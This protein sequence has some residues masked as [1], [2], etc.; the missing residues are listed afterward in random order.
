[1][2]PS[3][4]NKLMPFLNIE[5]LTINFPQDQ[6]RQDVVSTLSL[7]INPGQTTALVGESGSG[8]SVTALSILNLLP[9]STRYTADSRILFHGQNLLTLSEPDLHKIRGHKIAMIFQEPMTSLNPLMT[10]AKQIG[11]VL[12]IHKN[13]T[14]KMAEERMRQLLEKVGFNPSNGYL[15]RYP[16]EL[17]GG[18]RQ[19]VM[20]AMALAGEP[21]LLIADEPTTALDVTTQAQILTLLKD[22][23]RDT[24]MALLLITHDLNIVRAVA[25]NIAVMRHG[26]IVEY[27]S[28][29]TIFAQPQHEYTRKLIDAEP[30]GRAVPLT[31]DSATVL[32]TPNLNVSFIKKHGLLQRRYKHET[33]HAVQN[34]DIE[35]KASETVGLVG[36]SGSGKTTLGLA[37]LRLQSST[38]PIIFM[39]QNIESLPLKQLQ[40]LRRHM[41]IV[42]QDP[43][44]S[45]SPRMTVAQIIAEGAHVHGIVS[46]KAEQDQLVIATMQQVGLD[47]QTRDRY[48]HEFSGGQRQR[49][50]IA[51]ALILRPQLII[52]DEPTSALDRPIQNEILQLLKKLQRDHGI[53]YLFI[54]HDLKVI[55]AISHRVM[56]MYQGQIIESGST[57][58]IFD[59]PEHNYTKKL[60]QAAFYNKTENM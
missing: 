39:E 54:S 7:T 44:G 47:P 31:K 9:A 42:F 50:A 55:R 37:L 48:P 14:G 51:R 28:V 35:I 18:Q 26:L 57:E 59:N 43:F 5:N 22:I 30:Q 4:N 29:H 38:G 12:E 15:H 27:G 19:R 52:L 24:G 6:R 1:M 21:E 3:V 41:Q 60:M 16:H 17:S 13:I 8:K 33:V 45:L 36:E 56:V 11:E 49:I 58:Q 46:N 40:P 23:Q 53:A 32:L 2:N 34:I 25:N 10:V 20:I